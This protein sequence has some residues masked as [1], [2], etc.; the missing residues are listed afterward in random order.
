LRNQ[1]AIATIAPPFSTTCANTEGLSPNRAAASACGV[2][3]TASGS[4]S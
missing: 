1:I 2:F 4:R 3:C